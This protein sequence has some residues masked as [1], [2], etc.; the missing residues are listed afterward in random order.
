VRLTPQESVVLRD[1]DA[2][3]FG[4]IMC[5]YMSAAS[6]VAMTEV[7]AAAAVAAGDAAAA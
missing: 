5:R 4:R 1:G 6:F 3:R 7:L 2:L